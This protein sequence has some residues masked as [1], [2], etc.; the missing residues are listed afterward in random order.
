MQ[1]DSEVINLSP[2]TERSKR[3]AAYEA[4]AA[5][6]EHLTGEF[7]NGELIISSS[8]AGPHNR[9]AAGLTYLL[10]G[11]FDVSGNGPGGWWI[12]SEPE[13]HLGEDI[14][15]PDLAGWRR[16]RMSE[17]YA[18]AFATIAPDWICE[19]L[20][21][22]TVRV[23]RALKLPIYAR[24]RVGHAWLID[25]LARTLEVY[26]WEDGRWLL[27]TTFGGDVRVRA[28]PF[29]VVELALGT[30]WLPQKPLVPQGP[31][32]RDGIAGG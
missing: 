1:L 6:P 17:P 10:F 3:M 25:P 12:S 23:D 11:Q 14:L 13:L 30:L 22:S 24:E 32:R 21:P 26:R 4:I 29:D 28:E 5:L 20:S 16:E 2:M 19:I 7:L 18:G 9:A 8:P 27:L 15:I 31:D